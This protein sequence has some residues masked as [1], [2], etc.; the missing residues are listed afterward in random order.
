M[1][2]NKALRR[3]ATAAFAVAAVA[4]PLSIPLTAHADAGQTFQASV[5]HDLT[6]G[7]SITL[8]GTNWHPSSTAYILECSGTPTSIAASAGGDCAISGLTTPTTGADGTLPDTSFTVHTGAIGTGTKFCPSKVAGEH[9]Y[10]AGT[11]DPSG[12]D[13]TQSSLLQIGYNSTSHWNSVESAASPR[14]AHW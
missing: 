4:I 2:L 7:Q 11:T 5:D 3:G 6:D 8:S 12:V 10:I 9:C 1:Q 13:A 14:V